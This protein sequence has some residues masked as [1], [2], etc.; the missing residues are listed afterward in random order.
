MNLHQGLA[1]FISAVR[2]DQWDIVAHHLSFFLDDASYEQIN[3]VSTQDERTCRLWLNILL[4]SNLYKNHKKGALL[5]KFIVQK[6]WDKATARQRWD[7][8][9]NFVILYNI[10]AP[11]D[12]HTEGIIKYLSSI[13]EI[14]G[15]PVQEL[16]SLLFEKQLD[17][18][19]LHNRMV[20]TVQ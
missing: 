17:D 9:M 18:G 1:E 15:V 5:T 13:N 2:N 19:S 6:M 14:T 4:K 10:K 12:S 20:E 11:T 8:I 16:F 3:S 7:L